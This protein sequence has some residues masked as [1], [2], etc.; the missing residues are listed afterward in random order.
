MLGLQDAVVARTRFY[1]PFCSRITGLE[2]PKMM[3]LVTALLAHAQAVAGLVPLPPEPV[4][5]VGLVAFAMSKRGKAGL[6][7][8][9]PPR[10]V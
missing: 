1:C 2:H 9:C 6:E 5:D 3:H 10:S 8:G 4:G 7:K